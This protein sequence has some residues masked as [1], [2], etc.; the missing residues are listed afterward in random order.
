[1]KQIDLNKGREL[2]DNIKTPLDKALEEAK[3]IQE[4]VKIR[5]RRWYNWPFKNIDKYTQW[6][7]EWK[8][9][10]IWAY[11]NTWK[12][13]LAYDFASFFLKEWKKVMFIS[14]ETSV[15]ELYLYITRNIKRQKYY[16]VISWKYELKKEDLKW[17]IPF[18]D[19]YDIKEIEKKIIEY[20]PDIVFI[21][22]IQSIQWSWNSDYERMS[23]LAIEIQTIAIHNNITIFS[24]SQV[25][26]ES[27]NKSDIILKWSWWLVA[28]SDVIFWLYFENGKRKLKITKNK[29]WFVNKIYDIDID[30]NTWE[31]DIVEDIIINDY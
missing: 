26:N 24:L 12:S 4:I 31:V 21:D 9:Y 5:G 17:F 28:S 6:I 2:L 10:T 18:D 29:F 14:T 19:L 25:N 15:W 20:K 23:K 22:F 16:D 30:F 13:Q 1:M 11:S 27:K 3:K 7:I 8:V